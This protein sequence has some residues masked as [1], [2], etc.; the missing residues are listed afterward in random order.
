MVFSSL[1]FPTFFRTPSNEGEALPVS[2][3]TTKEFFITKI[4]SVEKCF[5]EQFKSATL[6]CNYLS[7][8]PIVSIYSGTMR[9]SMGALQT[10]R[11]VA[12]V[13]R[14]WFFVMAS[15]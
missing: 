6:A 15:I 9:L 2:T 13:G 11:G 12:W 7:C 3:T 10:V 14:A 1:N 4:K 8:I 5:D